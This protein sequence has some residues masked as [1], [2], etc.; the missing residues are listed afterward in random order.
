MTLEK[1]LNKEQIQALIAAQPRVP[2]HERR[3][4]SEEELSAGF[5]EWFALHQEDSKNQ[6]K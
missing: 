1:P 2:F 6:P 5:K 4:L 3:A